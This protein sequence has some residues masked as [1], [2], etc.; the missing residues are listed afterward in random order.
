MHSHRALPGHHKLEIC[1]NQ[2]VDY[3]ISILAL[4]ERLFLILGI[5]IHTYIQVAN[6]TIF[7]LSSL[8]TVQQHYAITQ[9]DTSVKIEITFIE[10]QNRNVNDARVYIPEYPQYGTNPPD[11]SY[12]DLNVARCITR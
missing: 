11:G 9:K 6:T 10:G 4:A 3:C 2:E 8:V 12:L 5:S 7:L 1:K